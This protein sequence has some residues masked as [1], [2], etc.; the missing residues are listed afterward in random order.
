VFFLCELCIRMQFFPPSKITTNSKYCRMPLQR[1]HRFCALFLLSFCANHL[2]LQLNSPSQQKRGTHQEVNHELKSSNL[3]YGFVAFRD[4][5]EI[6]TS[7]WMT[8]ALGFAFASC[9]HLGLAVN[10]PSRLGLS[11]CACVAALQILLFARCVCLTHALGMFRIPN[12]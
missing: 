8:P 6:V 10:V 3:Q 11:V 12:W 9:S 1:H 7:A 4:G 5:N 2:P